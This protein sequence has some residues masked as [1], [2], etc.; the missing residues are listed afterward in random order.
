[1]SRLAAREKLLFYP[2]PINEMNLIISNIKPATTGGA[3]LDPCCG[4]GEP[5]ALLGK[6]L[7]L[8]TYGNEIQPERATRAA[9]HLDHCLTGAREFLQ[10][11]ARFDVLFDNPPYDHALS[12]ARMEVEHIKHDLVLLAMGGLGI[13][14]IPEHIIDIDLCRLLAATCREVNIRRFSPAAYERFRQVV[15]FGLKRDNPTPYYHYSYQRQAEYL[16]DLVAAGPPNLQAG[17]FDYRFLSIGDRIEHFEVKF[18]EAGEIQGYLEAGGVHT[19]SA[20]DQLF[21]LP[22]TTMQHFQPLLPLSAG[23]TAMVIAAGVVDGVEIAIDGR[24]HIVKG[25]TA[26]RIITSRE[27][28]Q[29]DSGTKETIRERERLV[30][31]IVLLDLVNGKLTEYNNI[32]TQTAFAQF[33]IEYQQVLVAAVE[34]ACRPFFQAKR[35]LPAWLPVLGQV[36]APGLLPGQKK[37]AEP[38]RIL[39][40]QEVRAAAL[41]ARLKRG[42]PATLLIGEMGTGKTIISLAAQVLLRAGEPDWKL[43]VICPA[44][45]V[46]KWQREAIAALSNFGVSAHIIGQE[47]RQPHAVPDRDGDLP[48]PNTTVFD[49]TPR[50]EKRDAGGRIIARGGRRPVHISR[51][52]VVRPTGET[53]IARVSKPVLDVI[54]TMETPGPAILIMS[55]QTA[56]N[57]ARWQHA[58]ARQGR[59]IRRIIQ[60][61]EELSAWPYRRTIEKTVT[62]WERVLVCPD[63]GQILWSSSGSLMTRPEEMGKLKR[64]CEECG[65]QLWQRVPFKYGGRTALARFLRQHYA[66]RY[67]LTLDE[68]HRA[69]G[70]STDIGYSAGNLIAGARKTLAMTGSFY[71]G[72]A[73]GIFHLMFRLFPEFRTLYDYDDVQRFVDHHGL[74]E[75]VTTI[76]ETDE[77]SSAYGYTRERVRVREIP[78]VTPAIVTQLLPATAFIKLHHMGLHLPAYREE[79]KPVQLDERFKAGLKQLNKIYDKAVKLAREG[80]P[81]LLSS[82][83]YAGLGWLD[84]PVSETL[85]AKDNETGRVIDTFDIAGLAADDH[86]P[87]PYLPKDQMLLDLIQAELAQDRGVG[88]FFS[89]VNRRDWMPRIRKLLHKHGIYSEILRQSTCRPDQREGWYHDFVARCRSRGQAPVLLTNG[90]LIREGLDLV[91]LPTIIETGIEFRLQFLRQRI[92]RSLRIIQTRPV[93]VIFLYYQGTWQEIA[94][95]LVAEKLRAATIVDGDLVAGL[96]EMDVDGDNLMDALMKAVQ[97][98]FEAEPA[99]SDWN[100]VGLARL[101]A[102]GGP[103]LPPY[104]NGRRRPL[105]PGEPALNDILKS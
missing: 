28:E 102:A 54:R 67:D 56:K 90:N 23:H 78:G 105:Q 50:W 6:K 93:R 5:L 69:K 49:N 61:E 16:A 25:S 103:E 21:S 45:V 1:M 55:Y 62:S 75:T 36:R 47:R 3:I 29:T 79:R 17:E 42:H 77:Y 72:K 98:H 88:A 19:T 20:W 101:Q 41:V 64:A 87:E 44:Q 33:L 2:T 85:V 71:D 14:V 68:T 40:A 104:Q 24:P 76:T 9:P 10:V 100:G 83:M 34:R 30:H 18:P 13:W 86:L 22:D 8:T 58:P 43:V 53:K 94:L 39:P 59:P 97:S 37:Q 15:I 4:T 38:G 31:R 81:G 57:D 66:G 7:G 70:G 11:S 82:W 65:A 32:D 63:C 96:A 12:G 74:Q 51:R 46:A 26:K 52:P 89:Q 84:H 91:A 95:K 35:D 60:V 48:A 27:A 92:R 73:S 99:P 80:K